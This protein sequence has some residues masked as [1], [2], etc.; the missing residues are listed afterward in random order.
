[1][2]PNSGGESQ[3]I[4]AYAL[5]NDLLENDPDALHTLY[6][7]FYFDR[8]GQQEAGEL[9]YLSAPVFR[10]D[11]SELH[12]RYLHYYT[13]VGHE[14]AGQPLTTAQQH[15]LAAVESRL[16]RPDLRRGVH[17]A[18]GPDDLLGTT[19]GCYTTAPRSRTTPRSS[20]AVT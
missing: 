17:P 13:Q 20:A 19:T 10:W 2:A 18:A 6:R 15:A 1:M 8:R 14:Q 11:G 4:S 16:E 3:F 9:P 5:H 12:I 7:T